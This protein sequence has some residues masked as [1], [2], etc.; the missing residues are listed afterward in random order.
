[1]VSLLEVF[2]IEANT[3]TPAFKTWFGNSQVKDAKG[4]PMVCYHGTSVTA[5]F[6]VF[7]TDKSKDV[8]THFGTSQA[9]NDRLAADT[10]GG[11]GETGRVYPVY[12][13]IQKPLDLSKYKGDIED[14]EGGDPAIWDP[15]YIANAAVK[16]GE[17][18][19]DDFNHAMMWQ[20]RKKKFEEL[21]KVL[22]KKGFDGVKYVNAI[23]GKGSVSWIIF[24]PTQA[25]SVFNKG[26]WSRK[27]PR[28][29]E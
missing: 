17:L 26:T 6:E 8:G 4:Q 10:P 2:L 16:M 1:M 12:L 29:T 27:N 21:R 20:D 5:D 28:I 9:A 15:E 11:E 3:E 23:E 19:M 18:S 24:E 13:A 14:D 25:K 22:K 7:K